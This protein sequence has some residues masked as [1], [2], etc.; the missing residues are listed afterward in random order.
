MIRTVNAYNPDYPIPPGWVLEE[1]LEAKGW[2]QN[3]FAEKCGRSTKLISQIVSGHAPIEPQTAIEF[4]RVL[5]MDA[6]IWMN[7]ETS[8][9]LFLT[10]QEID[11]HLERDLAW[12]NKFPLNDL[13]NL[14]IVTKKKADKNVVEQLLRFLGIGSSEVWYANQDNLASKLHFRKHNTTELSLESLSVWLRMG[15]LAAEQQECQPYNK[16]RFIQNLS[17]IR[18]LC[19]LDPQDFY[20]RM[21]DFCNDAGVAMVVLPQLHSLPLSGIARWLRPDKALITLSL[22]FKTNDH[23]WFSF[24]HEAAHI[25][26]HSKKCMFV[27]T[28]NHESSSDDETEAN[29]WSANMLIPEKEYQTIKNSVL[30]TANITEFSRKL[31][32]HEGIIVGRLQHDHLIPWSRFNHMKLQF[33]LQVQET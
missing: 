30:N 27:D 21:R 8:Y 1:H 9:R 24:F 11:K 23:F 6:S 2:S 3:T 14:G 10:K 25:L 22:R 13:F 18:E 15:E 12:A 5:G 4:E 19:R 33:S 16:S 26:L 31:N 7:L 17:K 28:M 32:L 20:P 29:L